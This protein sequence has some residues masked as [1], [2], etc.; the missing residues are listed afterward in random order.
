MK[1]SHNSD[2]LKKIKKRGVHKS[3]TYDDHKPSSTYRW[4]HISE[5]QT[6]VKSVEP[7]GVP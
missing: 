6:E 5:G 2:E 3:G 7:P 1:T 4:P